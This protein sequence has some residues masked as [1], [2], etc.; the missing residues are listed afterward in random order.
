[1][2]TYFLADVERPSN[3]LQ[4]VT[5]VYMYACDSEKLLL[6]VTTYETEMKKKF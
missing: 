4:P 2:V 6:H 3:K 1:M 5:V